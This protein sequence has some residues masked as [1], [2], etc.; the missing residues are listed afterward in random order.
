MVSYM[1][2]TGSQA[3]KGLDL[4]WNGNMKWTTN[5]ERNGLYWAGT[6]LLVTS[7]LS[8]LLVIMGLATDPAE[9]SEV[10]AGVIISVF[11]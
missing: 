2:R 9:M 5:R 11:F 4:G 8:W 6:V 7:A 10:I 3:A 1:L